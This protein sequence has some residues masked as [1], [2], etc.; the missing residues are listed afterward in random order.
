VPNIPRAAANAAHI[1]IRKVLLDTVILLELRG[2]GAQ[3][4]K[5]IS[6]KQHPD[7]PSVFSRYEQEAHQIVH[8]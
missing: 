1:N 3:G 7:V 5:K 6:G 4:R 8:M 2:Y